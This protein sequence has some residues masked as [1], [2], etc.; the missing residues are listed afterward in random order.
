MH[1]CMH[2]CKYVLVNDPYWFYSSYHICETYINPLFAIL[3]VF[4]VAY[5]IT[6]D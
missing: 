1:V 6:A 2:V 3:G 5:P 4:S